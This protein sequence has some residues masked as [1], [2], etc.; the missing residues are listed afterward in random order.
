MLRF[1]VQFRPAENPKNQAFRREL[2]YS[3]RLLGDLQRIGSTGRRRRH[4]HRQGLRSP[5]RTQPPQI[6]PHRD[7]EAKPHRQR[8]DGVMRVQQRRQTTWSAIASSAGMP[9]KLG[10]QVERQ[11]ERQQEYERREAQ[12]RMGPTAAS[13]IAHASATSRSAPS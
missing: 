6:Q 5:R 13:R 9:G 7:D 4:F 8:R 12:R 2:S 10:D 3:G 11:Q 1:L